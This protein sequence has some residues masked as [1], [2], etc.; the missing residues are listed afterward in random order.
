MPFGPRLPGRHSLLC[1]G[2]PLLLGKRFPC[3]HARARFAAE[4]N[5]KISYRR[6]QASPFALG[7]G[8]KQKFDVAAQMIDTRGSDI[9][10]AFG[11]GQDERALQDGLRVKGV[12]LRAVQSAQYVALTHGFGDVGRDFF[13]VIADHGIAG[14]ANGGAGVT[15]FLETSYR[16]DR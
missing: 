6:H 11:L 14:I 13:S 16:Q 7:L 8:V 2:L 12:A 4:K 15:K 5:S 3:R 10:A 9:G 1:L